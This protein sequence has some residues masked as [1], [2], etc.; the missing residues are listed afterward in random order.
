MY[1]YLKYRTLNIV[2]GVIL[3]SGVRPISFNAKGLFSIQNLLKCSGNK[4]LRNNTS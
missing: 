3:I 4:C 2:L 1:L